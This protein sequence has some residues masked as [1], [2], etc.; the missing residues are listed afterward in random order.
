METNTKVITPKQ[1]TNGNAQPPEPIEEDSALWQVLEPWPNPVGPEII[2]EIE[3]A[4]KKHLFLSTE[5]ALTCAL[6][7]AHADMFEEFECTPR[8]GI[9]APFKGS[10]K[11]NYSQYLMCLLTTQLMVAFVARLDL[12]DCQQREQ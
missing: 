4:L 5:A 1:F 2:P 12:K 9:T 7:V 11:K 10:G 3:S 6:W 8:L